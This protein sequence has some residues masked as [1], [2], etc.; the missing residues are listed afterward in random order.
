MKHKITTN[1][2]TDG[3]AP[4]EIITYNDPF[5]ACIIEFFNLLKH[6]ELPTPEDLV[7]INGKNEI[8]LEYSFLEDGEFKEEIQ[9]IFKVEKL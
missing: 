6:R 4:F 3:I 8:I 7:C 2:I 9:L 1:G 5:K